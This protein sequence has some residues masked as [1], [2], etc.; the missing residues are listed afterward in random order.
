MLKQVVMN[1]TPHFSS[2]SSLLTLYFQKQVKGITKHKPK[3]IPFC[4]GKG[5][6]RIIWHSGRLPFK[7]DLHYPFRFT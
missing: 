4:F 3:K 5:G 6:K 7:Q 1:Q 2:S